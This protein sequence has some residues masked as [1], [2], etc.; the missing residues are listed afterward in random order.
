MYSPQVLDLD[1]YLQNPSNVIPFTDASKYKR[2][3]R[4]PA[5]MKKEKERED[6]K[7]QNEK[8]IATIRRGG[9]NRF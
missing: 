7:K 3:K 8:V 9:F 6:R 2:A 5:Q 4:T 1:D